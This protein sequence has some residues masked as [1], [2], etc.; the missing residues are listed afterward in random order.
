MGRASLR[1]A[2]EPKRSTSAAVG[3]GWPCGGPELLRLLQHT[4]R[5]IDAKLDPTCLGVQTPNTHLLRPVGA[6]SAARG[7]QRGGWGDLRAEE[8]RPVGLGLWEWQKA[9]GAVGVGVRWHWGEGTAEASALQTLG[10]RRKRRF[11]T[12]H[13]TII[14]IIIR[15]GG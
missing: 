13:P 2:W 9:G 6:E 10:H 3:A 1:G 4:H 8:G 11:I 5:S 15:V 7:W 14:I 12:G